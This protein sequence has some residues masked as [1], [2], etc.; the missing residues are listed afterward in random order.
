MSLYFW[1]PPNHFFIFFVFSL[2]FPSHVPKYFSFFSLF[3]IL[4]PF[5]IWSLPLLFLILVYLPL[6]F[7]FCLFLSL[8]L[9]A[10]SLSLSLLLLSLSI[11]CCFFFF[12]PS[13]CCSFLFLF[14]S[15]PLLFLSPLFSFLLLSFFL[16]PPWN[17]RLLKITEWRQLI[18]S[19]LILKWS[20][21]IGRSG[22]CTR[23]W[24]PSAP[25]SPSPPPS[26]TSTV[27]TNPATSSSA[28]NFLL[29]TRCPFNVFDF[30][31]WSSG[32]S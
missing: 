11:S 27:S 17:P 15:L 10:F 32:L 31:E 6:F 16:P 22:K 21:I 18:F 28:R 26:E 3:S 24:A 13:L 29:D 5:N 25:C 19:K 1:Q 4:A 8:Y 7:P 14:L 12:S 30:R 23:L 2:I 9:V 20:N